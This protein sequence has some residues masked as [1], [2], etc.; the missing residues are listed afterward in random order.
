M[1]D[2]E[3]ASGESA[4]HNTWAHVDKHLTQT[5]NPDRSSSMPSIQ[6]GALWAAAVTC[7]AVNDVLAADGLLIHAA[8]SACKPVRGGFGHFWT[9]SQLLASAAL[10][11]LCTAPRA[12]TAT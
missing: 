5:T 11:A 1:Q 10:V 9:A 3:N 4:S 6:A 7:N 12:A 2:A 8:K